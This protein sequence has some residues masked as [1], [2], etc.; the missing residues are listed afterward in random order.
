[1]YSSAAPPPFTSSLLPSATACLS[2]RAS[3]SSAHCP[4]PAGLPACATAVKA[5]VKERDGEEIL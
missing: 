5:S 1:M 3:S 2:H 4:L